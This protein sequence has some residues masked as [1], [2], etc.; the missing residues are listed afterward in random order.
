MA[1]AAEAVDTQ[2]AEEEGADMRQL[3]LPL[4]SVLRRR[5]DAPPD[6]LDHPETRERL[7]VRLFSS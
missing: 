6:R 2:E 5:R 3:Q 7:E 1:V 4:V